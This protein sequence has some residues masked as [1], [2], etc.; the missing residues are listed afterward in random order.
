MSSRHDELLNYYDPVLG[1]LEDLAWHPSGNAAA[2]CPAHE[3]NTHSLSVKFGRNN[4]LLLRCHSDRGCSFAAICQA[5]SRPPKDFFFH[6]AGNDRPSEHLEDI[7]DYCDEQGKVLYQSLRFYPKR[8]IQRRPDGDNSWVNNLDGVRRVPF[9]L[10]EI[11]AA[12]ADRC[13][14][15]VEGERKVKCLESLGLLATCNAGG[16]EKWLVEWAP[17]FKNRH[18]CIFPDHDEKGWRHAAHVAKCLCGSA[19]PLRIVELPGM[20][21]TD[22]IIDWRKRYEGSQNTKNVNLVREAVIEACWN[23]PIYDPAGDPQLKLVVLR[24]ELAKA[25]AMSGVV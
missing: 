12:P 14:M 19:K 10:N 22:D 2:N 25:L 7:E 9:R 13:V 4:E 1:Q 24:M 18:V 20:R 17:V 21:L 8:F 15:V 16:S 3:D 6:A 23:A 11:H 5:M